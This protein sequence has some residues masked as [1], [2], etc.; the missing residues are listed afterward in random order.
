LTPLYFALLL[1]RFDAALVFALWKP[2]YCSVESTMI[3][4][5]RRQSAAVQRKKMTLED[6]NEKVPLGVSRR[7]ARRR[8]Q[9]A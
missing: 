5:K 9:D 2:G 1:R 8:L 7:S 6:R 4:I 3:E